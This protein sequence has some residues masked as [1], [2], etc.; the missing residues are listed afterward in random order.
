MKIDDIDNL[1]DEELSKIV[2]IL[3][4][5]IKKSSNEEERTY[6]ASCALFLISSALEINAGEISLKMKGVT[7]SNQDVGNWNLSLKKMK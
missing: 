7:I 4:K 3:H 2:R 6:I 5:V 1:S